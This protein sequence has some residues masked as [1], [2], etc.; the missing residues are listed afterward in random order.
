MSIDPESTPPGFF[1]LVL[2]LISTNMLYSNLETGLSHSYVILRTADGSCNNQRQPKYG[3][4]KTPLQRV[5]PNEYA[6][7]KLKK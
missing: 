3:Q 1:Y 2:C 4:L 6:D 5:L 7:G